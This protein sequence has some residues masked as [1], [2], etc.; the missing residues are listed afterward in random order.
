[1]SDRT[2]QG[3]TKSQPGFYEFIALP[4]VHNLCT[5]FPEL[6]DGVLLQMSSNYHEWKTTTTAQ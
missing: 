2:K 6:K 1:M 4:L 3:V 5:V